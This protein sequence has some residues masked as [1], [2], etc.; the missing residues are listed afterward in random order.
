MVE[1]TAKLMGLLKGLRKV[2]RM[3]YMMVGLM[4]ERTVSQTA[5]HLVD[6]SE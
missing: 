6:R 1:L 4:V 5:V 3:E 2:A